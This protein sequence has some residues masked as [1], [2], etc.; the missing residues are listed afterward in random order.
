MTPQ[1]LFTLSASEMDRELKQLGLEP[2]RVRQIREWVLSKHVFDLQDMTNLAVSTRS[3]LQERFAGI[4]PPVD[5]KLVDRDGTRK[6]L[7]SLRD[8]EKVECV[9]LPDETSVTFCLSTQIGCPIACGFC[10]T[11]AQAFRRNLEAH[12]ILLQVLM[13]TKTMKAKPGNI[14]FMGM[15]E[16]FLNQKEV[17]AAIDELCDPKGIH[18]GSRRLTISTVGIP[19]GI[20]ALAQRPGEVNLAVSLHTVDQKVRDTLI[21]AAKIHSLKKLWSAVES[22]ISLTTRRVTFEVVLL[23]GINDGLQDALNLVAFCEGLLCHVNLLSFHPFPG[24]SFHPSSEANVREFRK[25]IKKAGI[26]VTIRKSRGENIL[27]AC[28]QLAG[29]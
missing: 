17:F 22:Y 19:A 2:F 10:R 11:G 1:P 20:A 14:V 26:P 16:P 6:I 13:L 3:L 9:A 4:L 25:V 21:P 7:F 24:T 18:L 27:A 23:D 29:K 28:G 8:G 12:E 15:G 5:G